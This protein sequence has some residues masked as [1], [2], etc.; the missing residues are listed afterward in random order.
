MIDYLPYKQTASTFTVDFPSAGLTIQLSLR[1]EAEG[2]QNP[3]WEENWK[4]DAKGKFKGAKGKGK[5]A[6]TR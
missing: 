1:T 3:P 4:G 5:G 6:A 2:W